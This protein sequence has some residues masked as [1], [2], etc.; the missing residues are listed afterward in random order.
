MQGHNKGEGMARIEHIERRLLNW[1]RWKHGA[2]RC[3]L[4]Y[5]TVC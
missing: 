1:A 3:G 4:G 5:A 2:N